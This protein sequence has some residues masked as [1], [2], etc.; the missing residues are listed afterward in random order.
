MPWRSLRC[1]APA[2]CRPVCACETPR[3]AGIDRA[4]QRSCRPGAMPAV[5]RRATMLL[6]HS[7]RNEAQ[8]SKRTNHVLWCACFI[9]LPSSDTRAVDMCSR[10]A[11][12]HSHRVCSQLASVVHLTPRTVLRLRCSR[13]FELPFYRWREL[14][15]RAAPGSGYACHR[16]PNAPTPGPLFFAHHRTVR[17]CM[18]DAAWH[19]RT[20]Y[21]L[22]YGTRTHIRMYKYHSMHMPRP[23][24]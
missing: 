23:R 1:R 19:E 7:S 16:M 13:P 2:P 3:L 14:R 9:P 20:R 21:S 18:Q 24:P 10:C 12:T 22:M 11:H 6:L 8:P 4:E 15:T 5:A 17:M